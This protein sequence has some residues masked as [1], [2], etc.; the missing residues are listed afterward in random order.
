MLSRWNKKL[1]IYYVAHSRCVS[2]A[3]SEYVSSLRNYKVLA[4]RDKAAQHSV[5]EGEL[6]RLNSYALH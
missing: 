5:V 4:G 6:L 3:V 2:E 1:T